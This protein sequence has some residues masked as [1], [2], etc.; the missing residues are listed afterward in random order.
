MFILLETC[1]YFCCASSP[2]FRLCLHSRPPLGWLS[3]SIFLMMMML[4]PFITVPW[5]YGFRLERQVISRDGA[6]V[7]G[8]A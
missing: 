5:P 6:R 4:V 7:R 8:G 1:T 2:S 3:F